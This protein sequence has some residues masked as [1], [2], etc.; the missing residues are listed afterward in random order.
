MFPG[1]MAWWQHARRTGAC[2]HGGESYAAS[3]GPAVSRST[4]DDRWAGAPDEPDFGG[5]GAFGVRRPLRFLAHKLELD[6]AQI[7]SLAAVL[8][9]LKTERA[10]AAV[11]YRRTT[12]AFADM[13][14][15]ESLDAARASSA[16]D[17]RVKASEKVQTAVAAAVVKIHGLLRPEQRAKL[18]YLLRTGALSI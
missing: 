13:L 9:A 6:E 15:D 17:A 7:A 5:G 14:A 4:G 12:T 10:Q 3:C 8:D 16:A 11:D 18:A 2:G 1:M